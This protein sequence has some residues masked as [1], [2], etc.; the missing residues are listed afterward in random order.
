MKYTVDEQYF[1]LGQ[2]I[3]KEG[4]TYENK[5]RGVKRTQ[6]DSAIL[7]IP[8]KDNELPCL[9]SKRVHLRSVVGELLW[10]LSGED[11]IKSLVENGINI[12]N[13]DAYNYVKKTNPFPSFEAYQQTICNTPTEEFTKVGEG[14][15]GVQW[16][17]FGGEVDQIED[18]ILNMVNSPMDSRKVVVAWNP[19]KLNDVA[20]PPCHWSFEV[21]PYPLPEG[22]YGFTLKWHQR[23]VDFFLGLPFNITSYGLLGYYLQKKTG[24]TFKKLIGDL[25]N[26][27]F[28]D[29]S[30]DA[31]KLQYEEFQNKKDTEDLQVPVM[32]K[33]I[34]N[35]LSFVEI[36]GHTTEVAECYEIS[37][38]LLLTYKPLETLKKIKVEMIAPKNI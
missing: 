3:L 38:Q 8:I 32:T 21:L 29:N 35:F 7:E 25:S 18:L 4:F 19:S 12:W 30:I 16:R 27:H 2:K 23:S 26:V 11:N 31:Y 6:V 9:V 36:K 33:S 24:M 34:L 1:A 17:N 5:R 22:G 37:R 20:L 13:R 15:Y 10:F 28:Y 14:V